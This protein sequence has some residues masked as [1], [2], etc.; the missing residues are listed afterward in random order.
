MI[1]LKKK[2]GLVKFIRHIRI[3]LPEDLLLNMIMIILITLG[4]MTQIV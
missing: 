3:L 2:L 1:L 4:L